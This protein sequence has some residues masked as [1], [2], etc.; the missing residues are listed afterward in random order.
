LIWKQGTSKKVEEI[1][2]GIRK[3]VNERLSLDDDIADEQLIITSIRRHV[4]FKGESGE[5]K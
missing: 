2:L 4:D 1:L 3:F 5:N